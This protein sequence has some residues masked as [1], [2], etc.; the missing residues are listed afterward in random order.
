MNFDPE[1]EPGVVRLVY[2]RALGQDRAEEY[3]NWALA[4]LE[5]GRE[6]ESLVRL[7]VA[8]PPFCTPDIRLLFDRA[9]NDLGVAPVSTPQA[10]LLFARQVARDIVEGRLSPEAGA[11]A[12]GHEFNP[13]NIPLPVLG[14]WWQ[15]KEAY[16]CDYCRAQV[17]ASGGT[18]DGAVVAAA[19]K[20]LALD[21]R[22]VG[23]VAT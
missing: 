16:T 13:F 18:V 12:L 6:S 4:A 21:W 2:A 19:E 10:H 9:W 8:E 7:A 11:T 23:S 5:R 14:V 17:A 3:V 15:L 20:L 22:A 1:T